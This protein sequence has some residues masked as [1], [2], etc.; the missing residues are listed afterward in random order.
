MS[1]DPRADLKVA[2]ALEDVIEVAEAAIV[3]AMAGLLGDVPFEIQDRQV[4]VDQ[5]PESQVTCIITLSGQ[6]SGLISLHASQALADKIARALLLIER[7]HS[8]NETEICDAFGE[9]CNVLAGHIK[10]RCIEEFNLSMEIGIPTVI[11]PIDG[12]QVPPPSSSV[13]AAVIHARLAFCPL[14]LY[15]CLADASV[16]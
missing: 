14:T 1:E 2:P 11:L 15:L 10:T 13:A 6:V 16:N 12:V 7:D 4:G 3:E 9:L 5:S 8:L